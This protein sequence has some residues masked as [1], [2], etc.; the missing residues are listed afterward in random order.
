MP[1][2]RRASSRG[3]ADPE[4]APVTTA[5]LSATATGEEFVEPTGR[6]CAGCGRGFGESPHTRPTL[7]SDRAA[8]CAQSCFHPLDDDVRPRQHFSA[9]PNDD[10]SHCFEHC[11]PVDVPRSLTPVRPVLYTVV[12]HGHLPLAPPHVD[13]Y[14]YRTITVPELDLNLGLGQARFHQQQPNPAFL[15]RLGSSV[16]QCNRGPKALHSTATRPAIGHHQDIGG[17]DV[18]G[19]HQRVHDWDGAILRQ[20]PADVESGTGWRGGTHAADEAQLVRR[21]MPGPYDDTGRTMP[22]TPN[23]FGGLAPVEPLGAEHSSSRDAGEYGVAAGPQPRGS[24]TRSCRQRRIIWYIHVAVD[25][26]VPRAELI[27]R[28]ATATYRL[29]S[30]KW[31]LIHARTLAAASDSDRSRGSSYPQAYSRRLCGLW[32][33]N[34]RN[35]AHVPHSRRLRQGPACRSKP[36]PVVRED[37]EVHAAHA[38]GRVARRLR[39]PSPACRRRPPRWSGTAPRWTPRSAAPS[40]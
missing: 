38:T 10:P 19:L 40:G 37:L 15:R 7:E 33:M 35:H 4:E 27:G 8:R 14:A 1:W 26:A 13:A 34:R 24:G 28:Q 30:E 20:H 6:H 23:E 22:V 16:R 21:Q 12:L 18:G 25:G 17:L 32:S 3:G 11:N 29:P 36:G 31:P 2:P 5:V 39:P 9:D